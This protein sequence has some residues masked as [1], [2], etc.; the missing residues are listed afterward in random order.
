MPRAFLAISLP[1]TVRSTLVA[2]RDAFLEADPSWRGE[3]WV[4][5]ENLHITLRF[6][7]NVPEPVCPHV[8]AAVRDAVAHLEP[9]R[10]RLESVRAIPRARSASLVWAAP[11][12]AAHDIDETASL[13]ETVARATSFLDFEPEGRRFKTHVTLC[14]ARR[15]RRVD[16]SALD[17]AEHVLNRSDDRG[18]S[19]SVREVTLFSSVL[20][21]RGPVYEEIAIIPFGR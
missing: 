13:A 4:A 2:A 20:T 21:P 5:E 16:A 17:A 14:R 8:A 19:M 12:D 11:R 7:G 9:Y 3:K 18:V 6:L 15:P 1:I 10:V